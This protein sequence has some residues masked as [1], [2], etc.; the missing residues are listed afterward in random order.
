MNNRPAPVTTRSKAV[1]V[2]TTIARTTGEESY[3]VWSR[4]YNRLQQLYGVNLASHPRTAGESLIS[5]AE[6]Y[7]YVEEVYNITLAE[8]LFSQTSEVE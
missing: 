5:V 8:W 2:V 4:I 6:R 7:G 1:E 3:T